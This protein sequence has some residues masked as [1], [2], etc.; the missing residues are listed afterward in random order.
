MS[1]ERRVNEDD[2]APLPAD[3]TALHDAATLEDD[4]SAPQP[5]TKKSRRGRIWKSL[6][7]FA[8]ITGIG[9]YLYGTQTEHGQETVVMISQAATIGQ[10]IQQ[11]PDLIFSRVNSDHVNILLVG[12]DVNWKIGKVYDPRT[13]TN[14]PYQVIDKESSARSDTMIVVSLDKTRNTIRMVS[15][16]RDA[17][18]YIP[19]NKFDTGRNKLNAAHAFGGIPL[20]KQTLHDELGITIH[21]HAVIKFDGFKKL[22]DQVGGVYVDVLGALHKG[23]RGELH[24]KDN[25]GGWEVHLKPGK[26]WLNGEQ[27]HGYVRFREDAEGDPGRIR[28]QQSVMRALARRMKELPPWKLPAVV[29]EIRRQFETD[30]SDEEVASAGFF[31][32]NI[33]NTDKIQPVTMFG[34]FGTRGSLILN[35][36]KNEMLLKYIFGP[37]F[38]SER[39]LPR[40]PWTENDEIEEQGIS[41]V[42]REL[43]R[44]AGII[45]DDRPGRIAASSGTAAPADPMNGSS[46]LSVEEP[47][48]ASSS[49]SNDET[50]SPVERR[51]RNRA[52]GSDRDEASASDSEERPRRRRRVRRES[53]QSEAPSRDESTSRETLSPIP[54][55][56]G[57]SSEAANDA[58]A[59]TTSESS[60][61]SSLSVESPIPQPE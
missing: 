27:A 2:T 48:V 11:E 9:G 14:R 41:P 39:F 61:G 8:L 52:A 21:H 47:P 54:Q 18:V 53:P 22:I 59:P 31:A 26:Q 30:M 58:S 3:E 45:K 42:T 33:D 35:K 5:A 32:K 29:K 49:T 16:P 44:E 43:L 17:R 12:R 34:V 37:T 36:P 1:K 23:K 40:S 57:A 46:S 19:E 7:L 24:Y 25:W 50:A 28:R 38:N 51:R 15:L 6:G 10:A 55:P 56:E 20:L 60:D 13:K 4:A